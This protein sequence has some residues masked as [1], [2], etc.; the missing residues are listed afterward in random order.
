MKLA[1]FLQA[2]SHW[3]LLFVDPRKVISWGYLP[4]YLSHW[5]QFQS[6]SSERLHIADSYPCLSDWVSST[7]FDPH[8]FYQGAWLSRRIEEVN[9]V[10]HV[11][12]GSSV[13]TVGVISARVPTVFVDYRP[14]NAGLTNLLNVGG[15]ITSLPFATASIS[16]L[17]CMHVLEHIGLGRYGDPLDPAG[18]RNAA[19]ELARVLAPGGRLYLT[20]PV[21]RE[22]VCFNAHRV[23]SPMKLLDLLP[24]LTLRSFA[25]VDDAGR[26]HMA[27]RPGDAS[28]NEYACGFFEFEKA[29]EKSPPLRVGA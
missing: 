26:Y 23:F 19:A 20:T 13:L 21:G 2:F 11:D 17:S 28:G 1:K 4:R 7:P 27:G 22:R 24:D 16:S 14:L 18:A 3:L 15:S 25:W 10:F 5:R 8:Y 6:R 12:V 9:P 29:H